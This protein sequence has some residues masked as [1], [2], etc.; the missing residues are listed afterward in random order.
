MS[1]TIRA[2]VT[3]RPAYVPHTPWEPIG[4]LGTVAI[5]LVISQVLI[6]VSLYDLSP[7]VYAKISGY[8][9]PPNHWPLLLSPSFQLLIQTTTFALIWILA[10]TRGGNRREVLALNPVEGG[11]LTT[12]FIA[13]LIWL[14]TFLGNFL[15]RKF[16]G[17]EGISAGPAIVTDVW[18]K[19]YLPLISVISLVLAAPFMEEF[20]FRGFLLSSLANSRIGFWRGALLTNTLW[21]SLHWTYPWHALSMAFVLGMAFSYAIWK[22]GSLWPCIVAHGLCNLEPAMLQFWFI[23]N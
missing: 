6:P 7:D 3:G 15:A 14:L 13:N 2:L 12:V 10:G 9:E 4:A 23:R 22:T 20:L 16:L 5:I 17:T 8:S 1:I 19:Q 18:L 11:I 21:V